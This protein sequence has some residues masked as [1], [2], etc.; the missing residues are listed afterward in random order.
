VNLFRDLHSVLVGRTN[1]YKIQVEY[2]LFAA[3]TRY[4]VARENLHL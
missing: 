1:R 4:C 2:V 3:E